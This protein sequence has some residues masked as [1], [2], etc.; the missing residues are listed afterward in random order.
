MKFIKKETLLFHEKILLAMFVASLFILIIYTYM[1]N[2]EINYIVFTGF[3]T[4]ILFFNDELRHHK[5][6]FYIIVIALL[7]IN[8]G[9]NFVGNTSGYYDGFR[10]N[11][12]F[13]YINTPSSWYV[14]HIANRTTSFTVSDTFT[15][16]AVSLNNYEKISRPLI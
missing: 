8:A 2:F 10:D 4:L 12:N 9:Q 15:V 7:T 16:G 1:G 13:E 6:T 14:E 5:K 3:I 11:N